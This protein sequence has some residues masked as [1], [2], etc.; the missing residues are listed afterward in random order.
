MQ[1][2]FLK[3]KNF[4]D[5]NKMKFLT[6]E[7]IAVSVVGFLRQK[8]FEVKDLKEEELFGLS[9]KMI[10]GMARRESRIVLTHDKDFV[11][12][13]KNTAFDF[14]GVV[15]IRCKRQNPEIVCATLDK[16]FGTKEIK[17]LKN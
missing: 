15:L 10:F 7:N 17:K 16:L 11:E 9:D 14:E 3:E 4:T 2:G 6:D 12:I 5:F 1:Q 13:V 8:G